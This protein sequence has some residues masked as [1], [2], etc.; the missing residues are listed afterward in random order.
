MRLFT[1]LL[2]LITVTAFSIPSFSKNVELF[3]LSLWPKEIQK[4]LNS[5]IL[6][7]PQYKKIQALSLEKN[8]LEFDDELNQLLKYIYLKTNIRKL[9]F[10]RKENPQVENTKLI[11]IS[12][13]LNRR[14][15]S[16]DFMNLP[17]LSFEEALEIMNINNNDFNDSNKVIGAID[18]LTTYFK[19]QGY[20][21]VNIKV[22]EKISSQLEKS[23]LVS[24][25]SGVQTR[26]QKINFLGLNKENTD[27]L[28]SKIYWNPIY[29][30]LTDDNLKKINSSL[31]KHLNELGF[32]QTKISSPQIIYRKND[33][34]VDLNY[35][36]D[37]TPKY[38]IQ[39]SGHHH[40]TTQFIKEEILQ[41]SDFFSPDN[42]FI[43]EFKQ[44][45]KNEYLLRGFDSVD[46]KTS[47]TNRNNTTNILFNINENKPTRLHQVKILGQSSRNESF[48]SDLFFKNASSEINNYL[49][50][51]KDLEVASLNLITALKNQGFIKAQI[52]KIDFTQ[53]V[54][55]KTSWVQ[56]FNIELTIEEGPQTQI[57][58]INFVNNRFFTSDQLINS[59]ELQNPMLLNLNEIELGL[60]KI[61]DFYLNAGF[62]EMKITNLNSTELIKY[63]EDLSSAQI[64]I[65]IE[66]G[67]R[68][69]VGA[70]LIDG[71]TLTH[72]KVI[73]SELEFKIGDI[74][75][76]TTLEESVARLQKTGLFS[77]VEIKMLESNSQLTQRTFIVS[78]IERK[79]ILLTLGLG[80]TNENN[81]TFHG[82]GGLAYR[83]IGGWGRGL[84]VRGDGSYNPDFINFFENKLTI[85]YLEP[86]L[87][88][89]RLRFRIN[90]TTSRNISDYTI[91]K[92]TI[93]NQAIW[94]LEK[95]VTSHITAIWQI[96]N[97]ANFVDEG[98][99][100]DDEIK[101]NYNRN[102]LVIA[103][104]GPIF[105]LDYRN[106]LINPT[107][108]HFSRFAFE[109]ATSILGSNKTDDFFRFNGQTTYYSE[110]SPRFVW[111]NSLRGGYLLPQQKNEEGVRFDKKG[112]TL[113]GRTTIRGFGPDE[114]FPSVK[115]LGVD[116][117]IQKS[118]S[119]ELIKSELR[120]PLS[121]KSDFS[122]AL[123]YDG[124]QV[125][126][127]D[128]QSPSTFKS[129][130]RHAIGVGLRY[131]LPIGPLS[132]EYAQKLNK[133]DSESEGAF[134]LSVGVF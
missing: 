15:K 125:H 75:S 44:K 110:L 23:I 79:P 35:S 103:L 133:K 71:N 52:K 42:S 69:Q 129:E 65:Q 121:V 46:I 88:D 106:D 73:L 1:S 24:V 43:D 118:S 78:V 114:F 96:Y 2:F 80:V 36:F 16:V 102:D 8:Q 76:P 115:Q 58:K 64:S 85:G 40:L 22:S 91:R 134:H 47:V 51:R 86:Y 28:K 54:K 21:K 82:Y 131:S 10:E 55:S 66:E 30:N 123:F 56:F 95:D 57:E 49:F 50:I 130:W 83:N 6:E 13:E 29:R 87:F 92:K 97:I 70:I 117:K 5:I 101:Y 12:G 67:P 26:I 105:D 124:G 61:R 34:F 18:R 104:T 63:N 25:F 93:T 11:F 48:Y 99:T 20:Q 7:Y 84:S 122:G 3:D 39:F 113:G 89:S 77:T 107:Q 90:Y 98:I 41:T 132:L 45:I 74:I 4:N 100:R 120:F 27:Y 126:I 17:D 37:E 19:N 112:F 119:F 109:Y 31:R 59:L 127:N 111:A 60:E 128:S 68:I 81:Y 32:F 33:T 9:R 108:G 62:L 94:S 38:K 53:F 116:Y 72:E 14:I